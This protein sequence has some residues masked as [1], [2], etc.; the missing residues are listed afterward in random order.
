MDRPIL[1]TDDVYWIGINDRETNLFESLWPLP[2]GISYNAYMIVDR[3]VALIDTVKFTVTSPYLDKIKNLIGKE[4]TVDY[5]II[6][7]M[8]PDHSGSIN[9]IIDQ[10]PDIKLVGNKKTARFL[11]DFYEITENIM[12]LED[13]DEL[14]LGTR[15]L[16]F[17]MTPM[18]H[19]PETMMTFDMKDGI[20]FSGDAFGGFGTLDGGIFDDEL[21]VEFYKGEISRYFT[22]I[23]AKYSRMVQ[24]ALKKLSSLDIRIVASTHGPVWRSDPNYILDFYNKLSSMSTVEG[25]VVIYGSMYG[26]TKKMAERIAR[27]LAEEGVEKIH[28]HDASK[29]HLSY[30]VNDAWEY[31]GLIIGTPTYNTGMFPPISDFIGFLTRSRMKNHVIGIFG[32][33]GWGVGGVKA[34]EE[35][36]RSS[37]CQLVEP[38]VEARGAP[39]EDDLLK[40]DEM[41][42][43]AARMIKQLSP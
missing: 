25:A 27:V 7:H 43:E 23:I 20:L 33:C 35:F 42:R 14:D 4:R 6:N 21:D 29:S 2:C 28:V 41:A 37:D 19:W 39:T 24:S 34:L 10:F 12:I 32:S 15:K 3:K 13:G 17:Y 1:I 40:L 22:N 30:L 9:A 31:N 18:V 8:E 16:K 5:L 36:A 38:I 11:D 26:N